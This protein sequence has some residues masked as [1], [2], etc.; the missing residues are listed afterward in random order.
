MPQ[1]DCPPAP[2][3]P[4]LGE[5]P[6]SPSARV[7]PPCLAWG[8][9]FPLWPAGRGEETAPAQRLPFQPPSL[10]RTRGSQACIPPAAALETKNFPQEELWLVKHFHSC[11][12]DRHC[13]TRDVR[14]TCHF[15]SSREARALRNAGTQVPGSGL[16]RRA[17]RPC[18]DAITQG[19]TRPLTHSGLLPH[20]HRS[21]APTPTLT[22]TRAR[23]LE[24]RP[25]RDQLRA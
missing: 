6:T 17:M 11:P 4:R 10:L 5:G 21:T 24:Q 20:P 2:L 13:E 7:A 16:D 9:S 19:N 23:A 1:Q 3:W 15:L 22:H 18:G 12:D 8:C 14:M 25:S